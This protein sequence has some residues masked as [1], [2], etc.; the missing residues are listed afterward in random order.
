MGKYKVLFDSNIEDECLME[1]DTEEDAE[2]AIDEDLDAFIEDEITPP[3]NS[4]VFGDTTE[5]WETEGII[6]ASWKRLWVEEEPPHIDFA[7]IFNE[8]MAEMEG[9]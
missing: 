6:Y 4:G 1:F 8:V 2:K 3:Y 9:A 7:G 5:V